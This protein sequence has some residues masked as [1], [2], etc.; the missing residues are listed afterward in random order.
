MF[1][2]RCPY[3]SEH[4]QTKRNTCVINKLHFVKTLVKELH[5][6]FLENVIS[7]GLYCSH[8]VAVFVNRDKTYIKISTLLEL[9]SSNVLILIS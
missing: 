6:T 3:R 2:V 5:W 7:D 9:N 1:D 4:L 8:N